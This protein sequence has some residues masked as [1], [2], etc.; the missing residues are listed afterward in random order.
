MIKKKEKSGKKKLFHFMSDCCC[1]SYSIIAAVKLCVVAGNEVGSK[2][3]DRTCRW[4]HIQAPESDNADV[5]FD[6]RLLDR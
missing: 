5:P 2:Y 6:L 4:R 1:K 3:P